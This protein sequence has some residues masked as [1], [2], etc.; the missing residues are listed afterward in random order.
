[1]LYALIF[2]V[3]LFIAVFAFKEHKASKGN[4]TE[5]PDV[6]LVLGCRVRGEKAEPTL[7]MRIDKAAEYLIQNKNTVAIVC[8]GI[9]HKDQ[10]RSEAEVMK[11]GIV[12]QGVEESR[13][14]A[15][16]KSRTT[17]ENFFNAKKIMKDESF[18]EDCSVA[19]LSSEFHLLRVGV[20]AKKCGFSAK[21]L[22]APSP[23]KEL[24][25]NY[26]R[27]L[28]AFPITYYDLRGVKENG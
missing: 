2:A 28:F 6:L 9:V 23:K 7:Q 21:T 19:V 22:A 13:V 1:M 17:V 27:E 8:G 5:A 16:D 25:K 18:S 3:A 15:E 26:I 4:V 20:I 12:A 24:V 10:F 11:E 14:I